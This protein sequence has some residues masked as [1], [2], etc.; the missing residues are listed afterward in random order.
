MEV[1][2]TVSALTDAGAGGAVIHTSFNIS[3][4][5]ESFTT[6]NT[7]RYHY[8][9]SERS[10]STTNFALAEIVNF[11]VDFLKTLCETTMSYDDIYNLLMVHKY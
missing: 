1:S 6:A 3:P 11:D 4:I 2:V 9:V 10:T 5:T 8:S 7:N